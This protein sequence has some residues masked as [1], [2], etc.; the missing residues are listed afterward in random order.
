VKKLLILVALSSYG[1][2]YI[3]C[4]NDVCTEYT[5][6]KNKHG[7]VLR[8]TGEQFRFSSYSLAPTKIKYAKRLKR[9]TLYIGRQCD[10]YS[11]I[12]GKGSWHWANGGFVVDFSN[13]SFYF[14]KQMLDIRTTKSC[15]ERSTL[16]RIKKTPK[17][18]PSL[19]G[20]VQGMRYSKARR[21]L[22]KNGWQATYSRWQDIPEF[23]REHDFFYDKGWREVE[24]CSGT[25]MAYCSFS[26]HDHYGN[27]LGIITEGD[28]DDPI[29]NSWSVSK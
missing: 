2:S 23:G 11:K 24:T 4:V 18:H 5:S 9:E 15:K 6:T 25:G 26:Y 14:P 1:F 16:T 7:V 21:V 17:S 10:S 12:Y 29:V 28:D 13:K 22:L 27:K 3:G 20:L 8:S 19:D